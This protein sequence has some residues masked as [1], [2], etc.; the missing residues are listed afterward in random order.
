MARYSNCLH[1]PISNV[2]EFLVGAVSAF[3]AIHD[4]LLKSHKVLSYVSTVELLKAILPFQNVLKN[5]I[6]ITFDFQ[7]VN[8]DAESIW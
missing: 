1:I 5:K 3:I 7:D 2:F 4:K 6:S 8:N